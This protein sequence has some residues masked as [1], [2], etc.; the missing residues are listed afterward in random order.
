MLIVIDEFTRRYPA[1]VVD[2]RLNGIVTLLNGRAAELAWNSNSRDS[3]D[4]LPQAH[5]VDVKP[6]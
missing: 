3:G 4:G 1:V 2:R 6:A 5:C